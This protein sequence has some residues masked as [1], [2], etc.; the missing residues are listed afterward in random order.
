MI[1]RPAE[2]AGLE[3]GADQRPFASPQHPN[4][5]LPSTLRTRDD[6]HTVE[7]CLTVSGGKCVVGTSVMQFD[8]SR[9]PKYEA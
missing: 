9:Y 8:V 4:W 7:S 1:T 6:E 2:E 3:H 5:Y